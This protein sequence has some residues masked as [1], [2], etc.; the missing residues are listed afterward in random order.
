MINAQ[1]CVQRKLILG[2]A[3]LIDYGLSKAQA[4]EKLTKIL[5]FARKT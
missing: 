5:N 1:P 4:T 2:T 3:S